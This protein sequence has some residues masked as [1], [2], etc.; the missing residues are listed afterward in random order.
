MNKKKL[1]ALIAFALTG[2]AWTSGCLAAGYV[3]DPPSR[4]LLCKQGENKSCDKFSTYIADSII[5]PASA[6][7][8]P[9]DGQLSSGG[10]QEFASLNKEG[11]ELWKKTSLDKGKVGI[12]WQFTSPSNITTFKYYLSKPDW[13]ETLNSEKQLTRESFEATPFCEKSGSSQSLQGIVTHECQLPESHGYQLIYA[14]AELA[15]RANG[16][17]NKLYNIID[18]DIDNIKTEANAAVHSKWNKEIATIDR[19]DRGEP[20]KVS[21]G[22]TVRVRFF[23]D[24]GELT[25]KEIRIALLPGEETHWSYY[26]ATA[27]NEKY[28]D[29][30]A[31]V[32]QSN[33]DVYPE[34]HKANSIYVQSGNHLNHAEISFN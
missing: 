14:V 8:F 3:I 34:E 12:S 18:V 16:Q 11:S 23:S 2:A 7:G 17:V 30:R 27:I 33:G 1:T 19:L 13:Q 20:V 21:A 31:G 28:S 22:T 10:N 5:A 29:I 9:V 6:N 26:V 15:N 4:A 32:I 24:R 25:E